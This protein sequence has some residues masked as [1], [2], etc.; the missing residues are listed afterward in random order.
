M[1][2]LGVKHIIVSNISY[3]EI[4]SGASQNVKI[5]TRKFLHPFLIV[6]FDHSANRVAET[7]SMRYRVGK[8]QSKDFMIASVAIA[9][10]LPLLTENVVDFKYKELNLIPYRI[11]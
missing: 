7:L 4:L 9:N 3:L 11:F 8:T 10:K 1:L 2:H 5:A 6:N